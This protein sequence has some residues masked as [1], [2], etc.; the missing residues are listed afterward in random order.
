MLPP[1][2]TAHP[3]HRM[4][5]QAGNERSSLHVR[6]CGAQNARQRTHRSPLGY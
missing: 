3:C 4:L 2:L 6:C 1:Q 5:N